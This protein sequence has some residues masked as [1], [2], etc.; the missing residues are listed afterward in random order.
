MKRTCCAIALV[1]LLTGA[2]TDAATGAEIVQ[3]GEDNPEYRATLYRPAANA[4]M[5]PKTP[6]ALRVGPQK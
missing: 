2:V 5:S 6:L 1:L 4:T 3:A